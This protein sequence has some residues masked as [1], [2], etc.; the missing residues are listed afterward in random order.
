MGFI[1]LDVMKRRCV[2]TLTCRPGSG[3]LLPVEQAFFDGPEKQLARLDE[4]LAEDPLTADHCRS[5]AESARFP[6]LECRVDAD[7]AERRILRQ[8]ELFPGGEEPAGRRLS[9]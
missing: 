4:L 5:T 8:Y 2:L 1:G 7:N 3:L 9:R 6:C